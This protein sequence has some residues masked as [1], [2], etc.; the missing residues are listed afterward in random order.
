METI[1]SCPLCA[2][3]EVSFAFHAVDNTVTHEQFSVHLCKNCS[4]LFTSPRPEQGA[5]GAYYLSNNYISHAETA[6]GL[7]ERVYHFVRKRALKG[8]YKLMTRYAPRGTLLD[9]GCGTGDFLAY[10]AEQNYTVQGVE[11]SSDARNIAIKKNLRV[12]AQL[13]TL[14]DGDIFNIIT[15]WHVLEHVPSPLDTLLQLHARCANGGLLLIAVP[16]HESWDAQHYGANWAAW[17]V[18]R[19]LSHFRRQD[20]QNLLKQTGFEL[21]ETKSMWFD[22]PYVSMLSELNKGHGN[23]VSML[24]GWTIGL[25]SNIT[26]L[27][28]GRP[29]SSTLYV[30]RKA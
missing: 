11:V 13:D 2:G 27:I 3:K 1:D 15:L 21:L 16:D 17:D 30:A 10:M 19:H 7:K 20:V 29:T 12:S 5:I 22:A 14:P 4:F 26:S 6:H 23:M 9:V 18:P 8:K 25:W 24:K 28:S